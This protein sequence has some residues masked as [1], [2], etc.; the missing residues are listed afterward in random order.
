MMEREAP[1]QMPFQDRQG[2]ILHDCEILGMG[3]PG[4]SL[5]KNPPANAEDMGLIPKSGKIL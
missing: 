4:G 1:S 3:F 2:Y 5:V